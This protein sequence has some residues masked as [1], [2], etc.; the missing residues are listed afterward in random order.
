MTCEKSILL[1]EQEALSNK[2]RWEN[3]IARNQQHNLQQKISSLQNKLD[4]ANPGL[5]E[6]EPAN[7]AWGRVRRKNES[8]RKEVEWLRGTLEH[9][10]RLVKDTTECR[11]CDT[12][13]W[14]LFEGRSAQRRCLGQV[15]ELWAKAIV[16]ALPLRF[17]LVT[18]GME[19]MATWQSDQELTGEDLVVDPSRRSCRDTLGNTCAEMLA[20]RSKANEQVASQRA[21]SY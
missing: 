2:L 15:W 12:A 21:N 3:D 13:F 10:Q 18:R 1:D 9:A 5:R 16:A 11:H 17:D 20:F 6:A 8:L 7:R 4:N 19:N 14:A